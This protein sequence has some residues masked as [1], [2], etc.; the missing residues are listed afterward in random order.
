M[1]R[2]RADGGTTPGGSDPQQFGELVPI[3]SRVRRT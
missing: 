3:D 1:E 2:N